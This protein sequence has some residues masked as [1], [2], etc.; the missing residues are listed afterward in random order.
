MFLAN[1]ETPD[2]AESEKCQRISQCLPGIFDDIFEKGK[3]GIANN[4]F[5][6]GTSELHWLVKSAS[7][8]AQRSEGGLYS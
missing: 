2:Q 7:Q 4:I 6:K 1:L 5:E 8:P 3:A